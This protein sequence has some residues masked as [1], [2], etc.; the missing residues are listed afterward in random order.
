MKTVDLNADC[1]E[2]YGPW[3][4]GDDAGILDIVTSAN[5]ACGG[6]A[7]DPD[8]M[9]ATLALAKARGT[10]VGAHPGFDD[11][12]GFGRRVIP[13]GADA[14]ER[15]V[16]YQVGAMAGM[17]AL[18]GVPMRYVKAHGALSNLASVER[19]VADAVARAVRAVDGALPLLAV[20]KTE[21]ER[22]G[23]AAGLR[24]ACEVF[25]DRTYQADATL[26]PRSRPGAVLHDAEDA[27][28]RVV[29][30]LERGAI[31]AEDG[32]EIP[33]AIDSICVHGDEPTA[34]RTAARVRE[35]IVAA[36][37]TVAPFAP[38]AA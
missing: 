22:A 5:I 23:E 14:I 15:M 8:T 4:M 31:V 34:V 27:A 19:E 25:A 12:P 18:A 16:A 6:H 37:W 35:R 30:M 10:S 13:M 24:V 28:A 20:A 11:K 26:T 38:V 33:T 1:G 7:G 2:S 9:A 17:A 3:R 32:T 29:R 36:G 21:L